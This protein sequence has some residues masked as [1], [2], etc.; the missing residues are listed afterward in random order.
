MFS[1]SQSNYSYLFLHQKSDRTGLLSTLFR[2]DDLELLKQLSLNDGLV[3]T[4]PDKGKGTVI[5]KKEDYIDKMNAIL[6]DHSKFEY[7]GSPS[8]QSIFKVKDRINRFLKSL[9]DRGVI[10]EHTYSDI[11]SSGSSYGI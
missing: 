7:I 10:N 3:I 4:R 1:Q 2:K 8:F 11:Y 6:T 5:L 9:K